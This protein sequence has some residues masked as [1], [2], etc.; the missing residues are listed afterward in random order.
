[1]ATFNPEVANSNGFF[2]DPVTKQDLT[3][4]MPRVIECSI[5]DAGKLIWPQVKFSDGSTGKIVYALWTAE[6]KQLYK[7]Y[8]S[9]GKTKYTEPKTV[10]S[11]LKEVAHPQV[12]SSNEPDFD[13]SVA[14]GTVLA[15]IAACDV[16]L[17]VWIFDGVLYDLLSMKGSR[18]YQP[19]ARCIIPK[20]E[21][22]RLGIRG[23]THVQEAFKD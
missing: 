9:R 15:Y 5:T 18:S 7:E 23:C 19:I 16:H 2:K 13:G 11:E 20:E 1:M 14:S 8:R 6:E 3:V 4:D 21:Q 12:E 22:E 10:S 17:G